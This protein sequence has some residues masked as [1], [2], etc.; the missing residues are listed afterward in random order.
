MVSDVDWSTPSGD[1][2]V[3]LGDVLGVRFSREQIGP[4]VAF[5]LEIPLGVRSHFRIVDVSIGAYSV[6]QPPYSVDPS[7][8]R[9]GQWVGVGE[10]GRE[11]DGDLTLAVMRVGRARPDR[12]PGRGDVVKF[13][14]VLW[15]LDLSDRLRGEAVGWVGPEAVSRFTAWRSQ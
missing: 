11:V 5:M 6:T 12:R 4:F 3:P 1:L 9:L 2:V 10:A 15:L 7:A 13:R 8:L 14:G